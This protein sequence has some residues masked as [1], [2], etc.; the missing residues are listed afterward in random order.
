MDR[1]RGKDVIQE[2]GASSWGNCRLMGNRVRN[3]GNRSR[4]RRGG[5]GK[6]LFVYGGVLVEWQPSC[7]PSSV[8]F[9]IFLIVFSEM[10]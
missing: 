4:G 6:S 10:D 9:V 7:T 5:S 8:S 1:Q 3:N 2:D